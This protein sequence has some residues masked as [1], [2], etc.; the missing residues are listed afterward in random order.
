MRRVRTI[1]FLM[2]ATACLALRADPPPAGES[3]TFDQAWEDLAKTE[4]VASRALLRMSATPAETVA[5]LKDH[6]KPLDLSTDDLDAKLKDL[7][8]DDETTWKAAFAYLEYYDPRLNRA[9]FTLFD[10]VPD[11]PAR[12]RLTAVLSDRPASAYE[13]QSVQL[14]PVG[15]GANFVVNGGSWWAEPRVDRLAL[16]GWGT[17]KRLWTRAVRAIVLLQRINTPDAQ[18]I[19][20]DMAGGNADALPTKVAK[21]PAYQVDTP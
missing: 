10:G 14:R 4:P 20:S 16:G 2:T 3:Q 19:V 9:L 21:D 13:G 8:S 18:A 6:L 11:N 7:A 5:F 17:T 12:S 15:D 1:A